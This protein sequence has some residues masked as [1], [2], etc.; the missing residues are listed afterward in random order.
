MATSSK[1]PPGRDVTSPAT[2]SSAGARLSAAWPPLGYAVVALVFWGPWVLNSPG[3]TILAANDIDPSALMWFLSW[4]PH[5][6]LHG[7]NPFYTEVIFVP[8]GYNLAWVTSMPGLSLV[9]AP[10]TLSLGPEV[11]WNLIS[12]AAPVLSAWTAFLLCR[13]L[14]GKMAPSLVGG[15]IFGFSPYMLGHLSGAPHLAFVALLPVFLLLV[16]R[17]LR[18]TLS[19]RTFTIAMIAALTAEILISTEVLAT[20]VS[21]RVDYLVTGDRPLQEVGSYRGVTILSPAIFVQR[22]LSSN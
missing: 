17:H 22:V 2:R 20:A 7:L 19:D 3:S 4:W 8:E 14:T 11:S 5:A 1:R 13:H 12:F 18:G 10:V 15:Y 16:L 21:G 9:L 6:L